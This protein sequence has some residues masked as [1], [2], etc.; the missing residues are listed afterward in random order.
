MSRLGRLRTRPSDS[1]WPDPQPPGTGSPTLF[2]IYCSNCGAESFCGEK[3]TG[4]ACST[5]DE[6]GPEDFHPATTPKVA[7]LAN[8]MLPSSIKRRCNPPP[9]AL[10]I[11][12]SAIDCVT[13]DIALHGESLMG[14][15]LPRIEGVSPCS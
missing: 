13:P 1:G 2:S 14:S 15:S 6:Y 8:L 5:P 4:T 10:T 3:E 9:S 11:S 12:K 7:T